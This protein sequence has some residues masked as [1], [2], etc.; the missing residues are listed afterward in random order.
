MKCT[1]CGSSQVY[2]DA[3][4]DLAWCKSCGYK[5]QV[6]YRAVRK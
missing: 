6:E 2:V 1:E 4:Q 3:E 5:E